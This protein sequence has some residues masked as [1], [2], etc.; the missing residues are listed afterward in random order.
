MRRFKFDVI[1]TRHTLFDHIN[2]SFF[3]LVY[4]PT[5]TPLQ[6]MNTRTKSSSN[7]FRV[8]RSKHPKKKYTA[9][10]PDGKRV[11]FGGKG[12]GDFT[13][14]YA[15]HGEEYAR[16]KRAGYIARHSQGRERWSDVYTAG[17]LSRWI[18]WEY[19]T[20]QEAVTA[21]KNRLDKV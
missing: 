13:T 1:G 18:L 9:I 15:T 2:K 11:H 16:K 19:P 21:Y 7:A 6:P 4:H 8:I 17:A 10:F 3:I 5:T 12:C 20:L 14:Y